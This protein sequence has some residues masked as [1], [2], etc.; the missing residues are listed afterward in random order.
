MNAPHE[1]VIILDFGS[2]YT[3]LIAR[4]V[5]E[6]AC[7]CE[8]QPCTLSVE[9]IRRFAP[10][11]IIL[12]GGP[13]SIYDE[14]APRIAVEVFDLGVPILGICYGMQLTAY[15]KGGEVARAERREYGFAELRVEEEDGLLAPVLGGGDVGVV[16]PD[17]R[18][19]ARRGAQARRLGLGQKRPQIRV[20]G[21]GGERGEVA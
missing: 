7:Y 2:Q 12:S 9:E 21:D 19:A 8:I 10:M 16:E 5:R 17:R 1:L 14:G 11:G 3:Q 13:S 15:L 6:L 20:P 18:G 4:R